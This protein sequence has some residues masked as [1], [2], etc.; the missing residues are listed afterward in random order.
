VTVPAGGQATV[1]VTGD[2]TK[3]GTGT[4]AATL[5]GTD[6]TTGAA[7][8]R[9]SLGLCKEDERY[10]LTVKVVGRDGKPATS[11]VVI[12]KAGEPD[13]YFYTVTGEQTLRMP[14]GVYTVESFMEVPGERA[15]SLGYAVLV[16]PETVLEAWR[17]TPRPRWTGRSW[18]C[19][20]PGSPIR[21][22]PTSSTS[23][24]VRCNA[25]CVT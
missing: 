2:P 20:S 15:D 12:K 22:S 18:R 5:V 14:T 25:A 8:T 7:V 1:P 11:T 3:P 13:P 17:R 23:R 10:D 21:R 24:C 4:F 6:A 9:T 19:C 16:D